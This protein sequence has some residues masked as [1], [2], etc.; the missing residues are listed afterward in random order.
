MHVSREHI[1][2]RLAA[3]RP[4]D[5]VLAGD[6][7]AAVAAII[8]FR[9]EPEVLLME[10]ASHPDDRWSGHVSFPGGREAQGDRDLVATAVRETH[11]EVGLDLEGAEM[12]GRLDGLRAVARGRV[13]PMVIVPYVFRHDADQRLALGAEAVTTFW[14]PL[15]EAASGRLDAV[16]P[17]K[18]GPARWKLPC[19]RYRGFTIWG[20]TYDMLSNLLGV[21]GLR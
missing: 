1:A 2:R 19:F 18:M 7:R 13:L 14:L 12:L 8:R 4:R 17:Y 15:C 20:L 5:P 9:D 16:H 11:E 6:K 3:H 10:R 21:T